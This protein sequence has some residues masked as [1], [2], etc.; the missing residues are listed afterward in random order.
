M[1]HHIP[2]TLSWPEVVSWSCLT[3]RAIENIWEKKEYWVGFTICQSKARSIWEVQWMAVNSCIREEPGMIDDWWVVADINSW[4][5]EFHSR[6]SWIL[7]QWKQQNIFLPSL[8][9]KL[10]QLKK[11]KKNP[12]SLE[13]ENTTGYLIQPPVWCTNALENNPVKLLSRLSFTNHSF[14][15]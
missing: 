10:S 5:R 11:K 6:K 2:H 3:W 8:W 1:A 15:V 14:S 13:L 9:S 4:Q 7:C 12:R